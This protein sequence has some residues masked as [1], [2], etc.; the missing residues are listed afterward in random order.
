[1]L[2]CNKNTG[3]QAQSGGGHRGPEALEEPRS[4]SFRN[5]HESLHSNVDG[6]DIPIG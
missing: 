4:T 6:S 5:P 3:G 2:Q 1:M